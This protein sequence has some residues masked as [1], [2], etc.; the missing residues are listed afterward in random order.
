[1]EKRKEEE[2]RMLQLLLVEQDVSRLQYW[3][4]EETEGHKVGIVTQ[5]LGLCG[6]EG[7]KE[8]SCPGLPQTCLALHTKTIYTLD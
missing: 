6:R 3:V 7:E 1:M 5:G 8:H 2:E 4:S